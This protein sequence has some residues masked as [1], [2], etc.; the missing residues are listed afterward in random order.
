MGIKTF[1]SNLWGKTKNFFTNAVSTA[2]GFGSKIYNNIKDNKDV[3]LNTL[4]NHLVDNVLGGVAPGDIARSYQKDLID[5]GR[6]LLTGDASGIAGVI[7]RGKADARN[8]FDNGRNVIN[9]GIRDGQS[10]ADAVRNQITNGANQIAGAI[11][12]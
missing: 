7:A 1:F 11:R 8:I 5:G 3:I 4:G 6:K 10:V 12:S 2:K 9:Q